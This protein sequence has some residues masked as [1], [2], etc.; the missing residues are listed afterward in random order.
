MVS[1]DLEKPPNGYRWLFFSFF[2]F[3]WTFK[4]LLKFH[5]WMKVQVRKN[6]SLF[7][8][9]IFCEQRGFEYVEFSID[10]ICKFGEFDGLDV[11]R[12]KKFILMNFEKPKSLWL[13][14]SK[15]LFMVKVWG[16]TI[17]WPEMHAQWTA[18]TE[19]AS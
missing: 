11:M 14:T 2:P 8:R 6:N 15:C 17:F 3:S 10:N 9:F 16:K 19:T 5:T 12:C 4:I 13:L 7:Q 1:G 18:F